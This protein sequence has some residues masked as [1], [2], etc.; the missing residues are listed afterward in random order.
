MI[1]IIILIGLILIVWKVMHLAYKFMN[2][3][4]GTTTSNR[5]TE[6]NQKE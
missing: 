6:S 2:K 3:K 5:N 1:D 4:L